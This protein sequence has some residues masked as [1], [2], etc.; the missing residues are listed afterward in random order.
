MQGEFKYINTYLKNEY[1]TCIYNLK[2][3]KYLVHDVSIAFGFSDGTVRIFDNNYHLKIQIPLNDKIK[4]NNLK[5]IQKDEEYYSVVSMCIDGA[6][7]FLFIG[8]KNR[9]III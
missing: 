8:Y 3:P 5:S 1:V 7:Q 9:K 2:S 6:G 4:D